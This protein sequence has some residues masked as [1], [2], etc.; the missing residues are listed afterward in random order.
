MSPLENILKL[1]V[2]ERLLMLE[3]IWDSIPADKLSISTAQ[4]KE[5]DRRL[6]RMNKGE[7]KF[8]TW[9][10]VKKNLHSR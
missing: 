3:K 7:T 10:E 8:F 2:A 1:S 9:E 4:K 6:S 5:L